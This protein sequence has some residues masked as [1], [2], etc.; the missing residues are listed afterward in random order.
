MNNIKAFLFLI[1]L[2]PLLVSFNT[3]HLNPQLEF[4]FKN[5]DQPLPVYMAISNAVSVNHWLH[6][7]SFR[8]DSA[9]IV[10]ANNN[11]NPVS[12]SQFAIACYDQYQAS[13]DKKYKTHFLN[14]VK[15]LT[16]KNNFHDK[17]DDGIAYPYLFKFH[18]LNPPWYSGLAQAEVISVLIRYYILTKDKKVIPLI[19]KIRNFLFLPLN[20]GGLL[21]TTAE[22]NIWIEEYPNSK[23]HL[24]VLNGFFI[25]TIGV[26][27]Y[28]SVFPED[29]YAEEIK[30]KCLVAIKKSIPFYE[31]GSNWLTYD[32]G[33]KGS[34][35]SWYMKAQVLE[36]EQ[37]FTLT[38]D[39]FF[40]KQSMIWSTYTFERPVD[41]P[42]CYLNYA[43]LGTPVK[44]KGK[45]YVLSQDQSNILNRALIKKDTASGFKNTFINYGLTDNNQNT[46]LDLALKPEVNNATIE[47][48]L[49][50]IVPVGSVVFKLKSDSGTINLQKISYNNVDENAIQFVN[51]QGAVKK[52]G[53]V[54]YH[55]NPF[56][57]TDD[58]I[59]HF[60][61]KYK[62]AAQ[63]TEIKLTPFAGETS[64]PAHGYFVSEVMPVNSNKLSVVATFTSNQPYLIC[65][66]TSK[67]GKFA[68]QPWMAS[69]SFFSPE[70]KIKIGDGHCFLQYMIIFPLEGNKNILTDIAVKPE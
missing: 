23:Q 12:I 37:L 60:N 7:K 21:N 20:K 11:Y 52:D 38:N 15:Y 27:E 45:A 34:I 29:R 48:S 68:K 70:N 5:P 42:G 33:S 44:H 19:K 14:Q 35:S 3:N 49:N 53:E 25:T 28:C 62:K 46:L 31:T 66:R 39:S 56:I 40:K 58:L 16:D 18:D 17:G 9:G 61:N 64:L 67:D 32:R 1:L 2:V 51:L 8:F 30:Q 26:I 57:E 41:M 43:N 65:Y 22:G 24:H 50:R 6:N 4:G 36:M 10:L 63:I 69:D 55:F 59:L 47:Y 13:N 54:I